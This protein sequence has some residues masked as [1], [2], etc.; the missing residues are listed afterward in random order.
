MKLPSLTYLAQHA[1]QSLLR[2]PLSM[3]SALIAVCAGIYLTEAEKELLNIFPFVNIMLCAGLGIPLYFCAT[4]F[5]DNKDFGFK[6]KAIL[7][8]L[9]TIIIV[10]LYFTLPNIDSTQ[11]TTLPYI[12]YTLYNI[13]IHLLVSFIPFIGSNDLNGFWHYNKILFIRIL[14]SLLYS[15]FLYAGLSLA[16]VALHLLF[17]IDIHEEL[18]LDLFIFI[19]GFFNTWFFISGIP[20]TFHELEGIKEYPKGLKVF[21]QYVLLPLLI[22]YL[23]ILYGYA[24]K[25]TLLWDWPKGIVSYLIVCVSVL[26]ILTLLLIHPYGNLQ[27]NSWIKKFSRIY[28]YILFPLVIILFVAIGM[29]LSD[30]GITINRYIILVLGVWLTLVCAYFIIGKTNI[31]FIPISLAILSTLISFG[32]WGVFSV[33]ERSQVN[34][35][36]QILEEGKI[37]QSGKIQNE[38]VW[39]K[40]SLP[41]LFTQ[42]ENK[43]EGL[44]ADSLHNEVKSIVDYLDNHHGFTLIRKWYEQDIDSIAKLKSLLLPQW[45][46]VSED[47]IYMRTMGLKHEYFYN[48]YSDRSY[49]NYST[50]YNNVIKIQGYDYLLQF[51]EYNNSNQKKTYED[52]FYLDSSEFKLYYSFKVTDTLFLIHEND[53]AQ[54]KLNKLIE[55]LVST[56]GKEY[57]SDIPISNMSLSESTPKFSIRLEFK[58]IELYGYADSLSVNNLSGNIFVKIKK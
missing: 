3:L 19:V 22:L 38:V 16:L 41:T 5:A 25:I 31:K 52:S 21:A 35:L 43:N 7:N 9:A 34:R 11:N 4:V 1:K 15:G 36:K 37:L 26:G 2:F 39:L 29:R 49:F 8:I 53:T 40:D 30:Y 55:A 44:L 14:T 56:H 6:A 20:K 58:S 17:D 50:T 54:F 51:D 46:R 13:T 10:L 18:Y 45:S 23:V 27:G 48:D 33:S 24:G 28:Y 57:T 12:R 47:E 42:V 32:Y